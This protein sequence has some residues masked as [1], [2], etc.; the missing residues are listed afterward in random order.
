LIDGAREFGVA[1]HLFLIV[2]IA[3]I[4]VV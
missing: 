1:I 2:F 4:T 3:L